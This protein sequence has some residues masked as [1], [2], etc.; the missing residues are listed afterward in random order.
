VAGVLLSVSHDPS[1]SSGTGG[2]AAAH[3]I[4]LVSPFMLS[5]RP[6]DDPQGLPYLY[7]GNQAT[8]WH[9]DQ[10]RTAAFNNLYPGLGVEIQLRAPGS[11]HHL[12][13]N[14][15]TTGW[16][17]QTYVSSTAVPSG[18]PVTAWGRPTDTKTG[19]SGSFTFSLGGRQGQWVLLWLTHLSAAGP[20]FQLTINEI[21]VT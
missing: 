10:Y 14:S 20:P 17:A 15:P 4:A 5:G 2:K 1:G 7:D 18:Q 13:V 9:T 19:I 21:T 6:P 11:V 3:Q 8:A 16:A 12:L